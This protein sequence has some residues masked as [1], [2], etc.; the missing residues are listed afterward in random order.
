MNYNMTVR[1]IEL[2]QKAWKD[3]CHSYTPTWRSHREAA[4][5]SEPWALPQPRR[6]EP[7]GSSSKS[8]PLTIHSFHPCSTTTVSSLR[9]QPCSSRDIRCLEKSGKEW[10][11]N[12]QAYT[13]E[14]GEREVFQNI[15]KNNNHTHTCISIQLSLGIHRGLVPRPPWIPKSLDALVPYIKR[16]SICI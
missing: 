14:K 7:W 12:I 4:R 10:Q 16:Y 3:S 6:E 5:L 11:N 1:Q 9:T 2:S 8:M 13:E 15:R